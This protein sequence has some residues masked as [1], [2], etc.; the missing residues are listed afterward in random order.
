MVAFRSYVGNVDP[1]ATEAL[2]KLRERL[3]L[4]GVGRFGTASPA[5][6]DE[7]ARERTRIRADH[8]D[9]TLAQFADHVDHAVAVAGIDHVGL[10]GDFDG[11]G[12]VQGWDSVAES[13][14]VTREL[15]NRGYTEADLAKLW[16]ANILRVMRAAENAA[17]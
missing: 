17:R 16:G 4:N 8:P 11:G 10:S 14:N 3:G 9:V 6:L 5:V 12:G 2:N 7:F 15:L 1:E 13:F